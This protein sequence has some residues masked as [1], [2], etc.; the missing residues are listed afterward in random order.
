MINVERKL[1]PDFITIIDYGD[2]VKS[3]YLPIAPWKICE[4]DFKQE[5]Y[6]TNILDLKISDVAENTDQAII[7]LNCKCLKIYNGAVK[8]PG[9][10]IKQVL[11][12][13]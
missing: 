10:L 2:E 12:K 6:F 1:N 11:I 13:C 7:P 5:Y 8:N 9:T 4:I 3:G